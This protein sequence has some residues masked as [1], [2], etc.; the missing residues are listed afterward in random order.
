MDKLIALASLI[1]AAY[2]IFVLAF[3]IYGLVSP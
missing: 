2:G 1:I 3:G